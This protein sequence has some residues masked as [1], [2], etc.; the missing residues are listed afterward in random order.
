M[1]IEIKSAKYYNTYTRFTLG[2]HFSAQQIF[3]HIIVIVHRVMLFL[4]CLF[5]FWI[6]TLVVGKLTCNIPLIFTQHRVQRI[7]KNIYY[8]AI[9]LIILYRLVNTLGDYNIYFNQ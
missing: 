3:I 4:N 1:H 9:I 7:N 2:N 8:T 6:L 5:R